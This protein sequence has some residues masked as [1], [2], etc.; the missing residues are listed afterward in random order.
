M[1]YFWCISPHFFGGFAMR[2]IYAVLALIAVVGRVAACGNDSELPRAE[3]EFR[4]SY[5]NI[6]AY[7][8][9]SG[10]EPY[11]LTSLGI[12]GGALLVG[13]TVV[14]MRRHGR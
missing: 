8:E 11:S 6:E 4:S 14:T 12:A 2:Q 10:T 5:L 1:R 3:R 7:P 13:A 9:P